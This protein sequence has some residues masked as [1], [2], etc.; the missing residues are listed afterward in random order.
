[1]AGDGQMRKFLFFVLLCVAGYMFWHRFLD[2]APKNPPLYQTP[3][4]LVY[5]RDSCGRT[6][7]CL[8]ELRRAGIYCY[9]KV[10]DQPGIREEVFPRM[11]RAGI[12]ISYFLLPVVDVS[13]NL[14][15]N[16]T[17][18][19]VVSLYQKSAPE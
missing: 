8:N 5:G 3:Y 9:Y 13:G 10:I 4:V 15:I 17:V 18:E 12:D 19:K 6:Q 14:F 11:K 1:M 16:P 7:K 2:K